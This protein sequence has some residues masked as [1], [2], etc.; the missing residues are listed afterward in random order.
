[1]EQQLLGYEDDMYRLDHAKHIADKLDRVGPWIL[2]TRQNLMARLLEQIRPY[3]RRAEFEYVAYMVEFEHDWSLASTLI[4]RWRPESHTFHL[5]CG[6]MTITLQNVA[7]QLGLRIDGD[8]VSG[9]IGGWEQHHQRRTIEEFCEKL[10]WF[11]NTVCGELEQD[12]TEECLMRYMRGYIMQLI[13]GGSHCWRTLRCVVGYRE[14][15]GARLAVS[16]DVPG[17][18]AWPAQF[19]QYCPDNDR[20]DGRL[21]HYRRT[22]NGIGMLNVEWTPYADPQLIALVPSTIAEAEVSSAVVCPLL[23]FAIIEWHQVDQVVRQFGGLQHIPTRPL[24]IDDIPTVAFPQ[25]S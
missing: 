14:V 21:R 5:P 15:N 9:C 16:P 18:G 11:Q 8:P 12:A 24:N 3:L 19:G 17:Y 20:D 1:M 4:E 22:L 2:R 25:A 13:R 7:Y 10:T 6:E 23:C